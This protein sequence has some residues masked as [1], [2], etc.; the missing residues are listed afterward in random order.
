M[1]GPRTS[2]VGWI[3]VWAA[4]AAAMGNPPPPGSHTAPEVVG[5]GSGGIQVIN[6]PDP[7]DPATKAV[8]ER[9]RRIAPIEKELKQLRAKYFRG[10]RNI[11]M[12]QVGIAQL[13]K[14]DDPAV[15]PLLI[16]LFRN[17][18]DDVRRG[19][20]DHL[21]SLETDEA[22]ATVAWSAVFDKDKAFRGLARERVAKRAEQVGVSNRVKSVVATGL[23][24]KR[25]DTVAAA[26]QLAQVLKLY[27][28]IPM[29]INAQVV[30]GGGGGG[31]DGEGSLAYILVGSQTAFI[32]DLQP[33]VG[34]SAVAFDPTVSVLT[35]GVILRVI[36]A[37][38][39]TYRVDVHNALVGLSSEGWG[40]QSTAKLGW[41]NAKWRAWYADE[42]VPYRAKV[43]AA[44]AEKPDAAAAK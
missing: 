30:G 35:E 2:A 21:A 42:F 37:H 15:F 3:V 5:G 4:A 41:D 11:E 39:I 16:E 34:D 12:R 32:S 1:I 33:V 43:E 44:A 9:A 26:A 19:V 25:D 40:G 28:A 13:R 7:S 14:Y 17:E 18:D 22:D 6:A 23:R 8:A 27:E 31:P 38:V 24:G 10:T 29:L 36:D 20:L